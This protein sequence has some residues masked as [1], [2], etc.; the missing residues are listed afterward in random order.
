[1][2]PGFP[3]HKGVPDN[4]GYIFSHQWLSLTF[5][6]FP[7]KWHWKQQPWGGMTVE[8]KTHETSNIFLTS[9][10]LSGSQGGAHTGEGRSSPQGFASPLQGL[11]LWDLSRALKVFWHLLLLPEQ[12]LCF[13]H[14]GTWTENHLLLHPVPQHSDPP[15]L[16]WPN[17]HTAYL[18]PRRQ[19]SVYRNVCGHFIPSI[20]TLFAKC[21]IDPPPVK[22]KYREYIQNKIQNQFYKCKSCCQIKLLCWLK[23]FYTERHK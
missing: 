8:F 16:R 11:C 6:K 15:P 10:S 18:V 7:M 1:M 9:L 17:P 19:K 5:Q 12:L 3:N 2:V 14:T 22:S 20:L 21:R 4:I 13:V 23:C